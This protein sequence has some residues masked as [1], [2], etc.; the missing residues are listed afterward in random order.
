M[1]R[2]GLVSI[3]FRQ[4]A[5]R[6]VVDLVAECGLEG[7]EWGGDVHVP[8]GDLARAREVRRMTEAAGLAVAAYGSYYRVGNDEPPF[9]QVLAT[10]EQL[11]AGLIRVWA[12]RGGSAETD[13]RQVEHIVAE[14]RRI[15]A[16]AADRG[17]D[18]AYEWHGNTLTDTLDSGRRLLAAVDDHNVRTL[19]Q[20]P[21]GASVAECLAQLDALRPRLANVHVFTW[22]DHERLALADGEERWRVLL[23]KIAAAAGDRFALIEF[24]KDAEPD[25]FRADAAALKGWLSEL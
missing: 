15:A 18:I 13:E 14:S 3:T 8:H 1:I 7:I 22:R 10:A 20:H 5:P 19:W 21:V 6:E 24:V 9:E 12:G 11:G 25:A 16:A 23:P 17:L 2:S 4:L